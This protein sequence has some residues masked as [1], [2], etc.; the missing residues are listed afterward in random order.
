MD[1]VMTEST[2]SKLKWLWLAVLVIAIDLGTKAIATAML[3]YGDPVPVL[4]SFNLTLL[5]NTGAAFS[6]LADAAGWQRWFFV[7][8]AVVVSVVL[9]GWLRKLKADETWTAIAIVLILGGAIG[10]VYDRVVHGY[11]VDF[12]HFYWQDW[13]FPA[14]NLADTAITIGAAMMI[15][16]AFRKPAGA[17]GD[18]DRSN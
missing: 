15:I 13:H 4:P 8:L 1:A 7:A 16:D 18:A 11:V 17:S 3:T 2:G 12:L 9:V 5:H 6:F 14:F 10:N